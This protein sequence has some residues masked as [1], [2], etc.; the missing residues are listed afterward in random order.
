VHIEACIRLVNAAADGAGDEEI[1]P[2]RI[3]RRIR[4]ALRAA[5]AAGRSDVSAPLTD[6]L[7]AV[8]DGM[9]ADHI[10]M[11]LYVARDRLRGS[12]TS[13]WQARPVPPKR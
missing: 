7:D 9:P 11:L 12:G 3:A 1:T 6:A 5:G 10:A 13:D 8:S 4:V 2:S